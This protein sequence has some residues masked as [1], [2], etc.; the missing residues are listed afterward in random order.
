MPSLATVLN[1]VRSGHRPPWPCHPNPST[2]F[3]HSQRE[4]LSE[5]TAF[6]SNPGHLRMLKFVPRGL[7]G[8]APLVVLLHGCGQTADAIDHG[9]GWSTLADETGFALL[10]P[11]QRPSNNAQRGVNWF[12]PHDTRRGR[13][14]ALS[15]RQ[16]IKHMSVHHELDRRRVYITGLSAGGAMTSAMLAAYP[17]IFAGGA[18][19]AGLP[20]GVASNLWGALA[21]MKGD[22]N[23]SPADLGGKV[24]A[25]SRH[26]GQWPKVSVW[27]GESDNTVAPMNADAIASQ[28]C[29]VHG[30]GE[31]APIESRIAGHTRHVWTNPKGV[32]VI[33]KFVIPGMGHG[34]P[35]DTRN[36][37]GRAYGA[38]APYIEDVG[39][40]ST[41]HIAKFWGLIP[42]ER[43][44]TYGRQK[45]YLAA[46]RLL[47][48]RDGNFFPSPD[49]A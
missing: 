35:I 19:V 41:C 21:A 38:S 34:L 33:E 44:E 36:K 40:S 22:V 4:R 29:D 20:F 26:R 47:C 12:Q 32:P 5:V 23:G 8:P 1:G 30:I 25:A 24:R 42:Q 11:E 27:H 3:F 43:R 46:S 7:C 16:M 6:G 17:E 39:I 37:K 18:I 49:L 9:S 10:V 2:V 13:G 28:W 15:I 48:C 31:A 45:A 14:E